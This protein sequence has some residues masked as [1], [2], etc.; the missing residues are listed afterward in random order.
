MCVVVGAS[1]R[2]ATK[3]VVAIA[4][5]ALLSLLAFDWLAVLLN[6]IES[7]QPWPHAPLHAK[8]AALCKDPQ[9]PPQALSYWLLL[10]MP[11]LYRKWATLRLEHLSA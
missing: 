5:L 10:V 4:L 1:V 2:R 8:V 6:L 11:I 3:S 9:H 7:S